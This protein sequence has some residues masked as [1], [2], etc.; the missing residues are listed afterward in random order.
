MRNEISDDLGG[1]LEHLAR[2]M[3]QDIMAIIGEA[4]ETRLAMG[5]QP[6]K[7]LIDRTVEALRAAIQ[8]SLA[9]DPGRP[10]DESVL[11]A[12]K[13]REQ[14]PLDTEQRKNT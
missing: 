9:S 14:P 1:R 10:C 13:A 6:E 5:E 7:N 11:E 2:K 4:V 12:M 8:D 3:S